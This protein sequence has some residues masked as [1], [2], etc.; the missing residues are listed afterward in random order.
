[1]RKKQNDVIRVK[2]VLTILND[3][4]CGNRHEGVGTVKSLNL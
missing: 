4:G 1:M 2:E 3:V